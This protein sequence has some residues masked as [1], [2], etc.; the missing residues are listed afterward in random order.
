MITFT[1]LLEKTKSEK[2]AIHTPT[3]EQAKALLKEL[4]KRGFKWNF[5]MKLTTKTCYEWYKEN[6]YY[7][8]DLN[9]EVWCCS[10]N[11]YQKYGYTIIE[12]EN[13]DFKENA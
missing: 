1:E 2:I 11:V 5:G 13:I 6:T 7:D 9:K 8:F 10:Y 3:E 4:D 12:F